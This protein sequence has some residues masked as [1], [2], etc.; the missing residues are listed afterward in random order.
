MIFIPFVF[1]LVTTNYTF[2]SP[3]NLNAS[4][5][6]DRSRLFDYKNKCNNCSEAIEITFAC[7]MELTNINEVYCLQSN[8]LVLPN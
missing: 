7:S 3:Y 6:K 1:K 4:I 8:I 5:G 2:L